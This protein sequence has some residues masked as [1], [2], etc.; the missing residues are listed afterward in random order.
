MRISKMWMVVLAI[1]LALWGLLLLEV[2]DFSS[3]TD[4]IGVGAIAS[5]VLLL[6]D[7]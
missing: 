7:K 4:I 2:L 1:T 6:L 5:A 3:A